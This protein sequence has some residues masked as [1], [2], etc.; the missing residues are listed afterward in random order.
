MLFC[1]GSF[2]KRNILEKRV[3]LD[4]GL[5]NVELNEVKFRCALMESHATNEQLHQQMNRWK[6]LAAANSSH[7][8]PPSSLTSFNDMLNG[9]SGIGFERV[10]T[11]TTP[12]TPTPASSLIQEAKADIERM[13]Q[14]ITGS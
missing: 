14:S 8:L 5:N 7:R 12:T 9:T 3:D 10:T 13:K 1:S 2:C 6:T 4:S 11:P